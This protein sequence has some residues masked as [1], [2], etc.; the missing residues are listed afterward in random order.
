MIRYF[1]LLVILIFIPTLLI[2]STKTF[3]PDFYRQVNYLLTSKQNMSEP[4]VLK[5]HQIVQHI[6]KTTED[7]EGFVQKVK[8]LKAYLRIICDLSQLQALQ[9]ALLLEEEINSRIESWNK[10]TKRRRGTISWTAIAL[11]ALLGLLIVVFRAI[12]EDR[13]ELEQLRKMGIDILIWAPLTIGGGLSVGNVIAAKEVE[14]N[15]MLL[16]HPAELMRAHAGDVATYEIESQLKAFLAAKDKSSRSQVIQKKIQALHSKAPERVSS[17]IR[18]MNKVI[19]YAPQEVLE[20]PKEEQQERLEILQKSLSTEFS[21]TSMTTTWWDELRYFLS[22]YTYKIAIVGAILGAI[23]FLLP[24]CF[25]NGWSWPYAAL[26]LVI[27]LS[28]GLSLG[29]MG[30]ELIKKETP[31]EILYH[32]AAF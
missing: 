10:E 29:Q 27:G 9:R 28:V 11:G 15:P 17:R 22:D 18:Y 26:L 24:L 25:S 14:H 6:V 32:E 7:R 20:I 2:A 31:Q 21:S 1:S 8:E 3:P 23:I 5:A 19:K 4:L 16:V 12:R 13:L 30:G